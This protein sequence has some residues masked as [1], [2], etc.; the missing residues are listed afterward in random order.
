MLVIWA[1]GVSAVL[2]AAPIMIP[3]NP[4]RVKLVSEGQSYPSVAERDCLVL[5][6]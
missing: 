2:G 4:L 5:T 1:R 6:M 3:F